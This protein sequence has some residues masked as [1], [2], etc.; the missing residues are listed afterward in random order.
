LEKK[1]EKIEYAQI[2]ILKNKLNDIL[3]LAEK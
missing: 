1:A 3:G 2:D